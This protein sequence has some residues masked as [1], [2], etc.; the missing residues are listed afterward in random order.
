MLLGVRFAWRTVLSFPG[1]EILIK[2]ARH[3]LMLKLELS[4]VLLFVLEKVE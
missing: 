2:R 1:L 4:L 3:C